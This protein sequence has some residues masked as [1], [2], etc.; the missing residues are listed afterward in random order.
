MSALCSVGTGTVADGDGC[1]EVARIAAWQR[2]R[3]EQQAEY[4]GCDVVPKCNVNMAAW[5]RF[6]TAPACMQ[7]CCYISNCGT[8][9]CKAPPPKSASCRGNTFMKP[10]DAEFFLCM[11]GRTTAEL[12]KDACRGPWC[13]PCFRNTEGSYH[14]HDDFLRVDAHGQHT[15]VRRDATPLVT[16]TREW[17]ATDAPLMP[18]DMLSPDEVAEGCICG[19]E[20]TEVNPPAGMPFCPR[21]HARHYLNGDV[22]VP[23]HADCLVHTMKHALGDTVAMTLEDSTLIVVCPTC[24]YEEKVASI[25]RDFD[26]GLRHVADAWTAAKRVDQN[27]WAA[28]AVAA[29]DSLHVRVQPSAETEA[30]WAE[31]VAAAHGALRALHPQPLYRQLAERAAAAAAEWN[32][33]A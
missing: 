9:N 17:G 30:N 6:W 15:I 33:T 19:M 13:G 11:H 14:P 27:A 25:S 5:Q 1:S 29:Y 21:K 16:A 3:A 10:P 18:L 24:I 31:F 22:L 26:A 2:A 7:P 32:A 28:A 20:F 8:T 4:D 12:S 23:L